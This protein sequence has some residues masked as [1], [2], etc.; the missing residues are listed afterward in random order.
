MRMNIEQ[1]PKPSDVDA[2]PVRTWGKPPPSSTR[3]K[4]TLS[5]ST[6][7]LMTAC[8]QQEFCSNTG[9]P[10]Q[11]AARRRSNRPS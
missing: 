3:A 2:D 8:W 10:T 5:G 9:D 7:A 1:V 11:C 4:V 6:G